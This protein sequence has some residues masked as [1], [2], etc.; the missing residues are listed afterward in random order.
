LWPTGLT[1][2]L[3]HGAGHGIP[4]TWNETAL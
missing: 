2:C 1:V 4:F 3:G